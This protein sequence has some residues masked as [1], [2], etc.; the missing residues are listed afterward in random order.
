MPQQ[1]TVNQLFAPAPS[2]VGPYGIVGGAVV[3]A[4]PQVPGAGTW[5][6][7]QLGIAATVQLPTSSWQPGD[8]ERTILATES[9][10]FALSDA[11]ISAMA[12]GGFLQS[13]ASGTVTYT[14]PQGATTTIP[15]TPDPSNA[16]QN[17]TGA[18]GY[19][20]LL[21]A[22]VYEVTR[23]QATPASGPLAIAKLSGGTIAYAAGAYHVENTLTGAT[24]H[25]P[26]SIT[27]AGTAPPGAGGGV[28]GVTPGLSSTIIT[29]ASAPGF[30]PG[31]S[32]YLNIPQTSGVSGLAGVF[33]VVTAAF[34]LSSSFQVALGSSGTFT[35]G[36]N[37]YLCTVA[38]MTAD[39]VGTAGNASPG[40][41]TTAVSQN[42]NVFVGNPGAWS[43]ANWESNAALAYRC[44]LSLAARS[45]NGAAAAYVYFALS[46]YQLLQNATP[47]YTLTNGPVRASNF[48]TPATGVVTTVVGSASPA[49]TTLGAAVTPGCSQL[50]I[51][52][53]TLGNPTII[54]CAG[55]T[56]LPAGQSTVT[57]SGA[58][59]VNGTING[60][61]LATYTGADGFSIPIDTTGLPAWSG[62]GTVEG[63]DLGAIDALLQ[64][65]VVPDNTS[66]RTVS[67]LAQPIQVTATVIVPQA[68]VAAY[69][70]ASVTQ[71]G[72]QVA[73]YPFGGNAADGFSVP[74]LDI[75]G[76]LELAG[77]PN[78][79]APALG[80]AS[81]AEVQSLS[82][83]GQGANVG[84]P[85]AGNTYMA[86]LV[87][88]LV[89]VVGT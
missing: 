78:P 73:S 85:F 79:A 62:G 80:Q 28:V 75:V 42:A 68:Y 3:G 66:A 5:L 7:M 40:A 72:A 33:A 32:V 45:P 37:V 43:G 39:V 10:C 81:Y 14:D 8:P 19:E 88:P 50:P 35:S 13:A 29:T 11:N 56:G 71:L 83:N 64:Q 60:T 57:I 58:L 4:V 41:T 53:V 22:N 76:A 61:F 74:Y 54:G 31:Q 84:Q 23:L 15:V 36:G 67:A 47:S 69:Q 63:S 25:N 21:A 16:A 49:S 26:A 27:I 18:P 70:L 12:Q 17:P 38:T 86:V 52:S 30:T 6:S 89:T 55:P 46:A 59:G 48:S 20:D 2:G 44:Q 24:Y 51:A 82:I 77:L 9:V 1:L 65:N 34:P 87:N